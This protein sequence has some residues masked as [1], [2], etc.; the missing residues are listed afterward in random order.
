MNMSTTNNNES[1]N[2]LPSPNIIPHQMLKY[3]NI[4]PLVEYRSIR[5]AVLSYNDTKPGLYL[6]YINM[7]VFMFICYLSLSL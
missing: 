6:F 1:Q 2:S 7:N 5:S 4:A 3:I